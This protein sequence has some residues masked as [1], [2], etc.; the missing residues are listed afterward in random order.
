[1]SQS[2]LALCARGVAGEVV[3]AALRAGSAA[4]RCREC[5]GRAGKA[6][7]L[8]RLSL[9]KPRRAEVARPGCVLRGPAESA[10]RTREGAVRA[11]VA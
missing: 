9:M 4:F 10:G 5:P 6:T 11:V 2:V 1:M 8:P 3:Q 7:G